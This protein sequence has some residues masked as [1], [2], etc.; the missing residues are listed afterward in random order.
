MGAAHLRA[1]A[2]LQSGTPGT[3]GEADGWSCSHVHE[4]VECSASQA[5]ISDL[6]E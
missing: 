4:E 6:Y 1:A 3:A 5:A 2:A